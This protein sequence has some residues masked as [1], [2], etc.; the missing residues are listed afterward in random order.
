MEDIQ[1]N[2]KLWSGMRE[3]RSHHRRSENWE[4]SRKI[5]RRWSIEVAEPYGPDFACSEE[6]RP[7]H[8]I[9]R[10]WGDG[11]MGKPYDG[12]LRRWRVSG[13]LSV[14]KG[15]KY[16]SGGACGCGGVKTVELI[17]LQRR[18]YTNLGQ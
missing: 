12:S 11:E 17:A 7:D 3:I 1:W 15:F 14:G 8:D 10:L 16:S 4:M 6:W 9:M 2:G 18:L 5:R 13:G